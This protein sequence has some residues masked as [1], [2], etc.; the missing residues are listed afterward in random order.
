MHRNR[1]VAT[2]GIAAV[3]VLALGTAWTHVSAGSR[4]HQAQQADTGD[5]LAPLN[6]ISV[7]T[8]TGTSFTVPANGT[9]GLTITCTS[10]ISVAKTPLQAGGTIQNLLPLPPT[11]DDG[12]G[13]N[14]IPKKCTD[15]LNGTTV[16]TTKGPWAAQAIDNASDTE[17]NIDTVDVIVPK[18]GAVVKTSEGCT[19]TVAPQAAYT[20]VGSYNDSTGVLS[21]NLTDPINGLPALVQG[22]GLCPT[23]PPAASCSGQS[24]AFCS[25]FRGDYT[26]SPKLSG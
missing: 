11:F 10:S 6:S 12:P 23:T 8:N 25:T 4:V 15:N 9:G 21:V 13:P 20:V 5:V 24:P 1:K 26:W 7:G 18:A 17:P 3:G 19:I 2:L 14:G 22:G 16:T